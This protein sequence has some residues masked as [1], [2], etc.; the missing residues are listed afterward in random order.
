MS[1]DPGVTG[2]RRWLFV[3]TIFAGSFLLFLVQPMVARMALPHL[4]G[5]PNVWNSA[6]LVYQA[7][8]LVG[9]A[10]AHALSRLPV[11]R[12]AAL[13]L[14]LLLVAGLT[15]PIAL[16]DL[17]PPAPGSEALWVPW[18]FLLTIG[19]LF[20]V[21]A[22][23]APLMQRWFAAHPEAGDPYPLYAASNLGSFAG[24]LAYPLLAEPLMPL[25][26]QSALWAVGY[27][28]LIVL[29]ALTGLA[30]RRVTA[31][32]QDA[33]AAA[34]P[35]AAPPSGRRILLWLALSAVPS[36]L[37]LSTTTHLTT[38]VFAMPLL[39]VIPLGL[40][41]LSFTIAF[42]PRRWLAQA[43][44]AIAPL[45]VCADGAIVMLAAERPSLLAAF[46]SLVLLFIA[47]IALH[48]RLFETRPEPARLTQFYLVMSCG[49]VLGGL[50]TALLAP[51]LFDWTWE[52]PLLILAAAALLP[53]AG[54]NKL[55]GFIAKGP[56]AVP[57]GVVGLLLV[58]ALAAYLLERELAR[59]QELGGYTFGLLA[60]LV[61][62][63]MLLSAR[64]WAFVA[65]SA[66]ILVAAGGAEQLRTTLDGKRSRSYFGVYTVEDLPIG[67]RQ[68]LHGTTLHGT[69]R[70][71]NGAETA[72]TTYFGPTSG[73]GQALLAADRLYGEGARVGV[74]GLGV[75]T[76]AC[77]RRP[78]QA[79]TFFEI[80]PTVLGFSQRH[81]FTFL[82]RCAPRVPVVIGDARLKLAEVDPG[83]FDILVID[84]FSSDAVPI[85]LVTEEALDIYLRALAPDGLLLVH[86]SNR[87][88]DLEPPMAA[89]AEKKQLSAALRYD[90]SEAAAM[91][92]SD[93]IVMSRDPS[94]LVSLTLTGG[95]QPLAPP[96]T[97]VWTDDFVS[98]LPYF[99][100]RYFF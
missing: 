51:L 90:A 83:S 3:A 40:Y 26:E 62:G 72:P 38:D 95:W 41:L 25:R 6:M 66:I 55:L 97:S 87:Y 23:Q 31:A 15:L 43:I 12:Q 14:A 32:P 78:D 10:Y 36:G 28:V 75:G 79:W 47:A 63:A 37:M 59:F 57:T 49:G 67:D 61:A 4:G 19:P 20:F 99:T 86:I 39:W 70:H 5:A 85:H 74:L 9:Y 98:I 73:V 56:N 81:V 18:L 7:L 58:V 77:Y 96:A 27:G 24:L 30:R 84:A 11:A 71:D 88:V 92:Q 80:D 91:E 93:W 65:A 21:V 34:E 60:A 44:V 45:V 94:M 42:A 29:V 82:D 89:L 2:A 35:A 48:A 64:R 69:Q 17:A 16:P 22:A 68:L 8:L 52:H 76:L 54:W 100:W 53:L 13:H 50:F 1:A 33:G 46:A